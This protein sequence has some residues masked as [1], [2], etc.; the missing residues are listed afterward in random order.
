M[1]NTPWR[2]ATAIALFSLAACGGGGGTAT[3]PMSAPMLVT[4]TTMLTDND[5]STD[6]DGDDG[7]NFLRAAGAPV[8]IGST[9]DPINGDQNPYGL[10]VAKTSSPPISAGDLVICNFNDGPTNT[11]G[12]GTTIVALHPQVGSTPVRVAQS[13]SL[14]GCNALALAPSDTI[15]AADFVANNDAI[16]R[17][18]GTIVS[19][20]P[21]GPWHGPFGEAFSATPGP[22]GSAAFYVTN[23]GDGS[24]V[25]VDIHPN[26][27]FTFNVIATG[28]AINGGAPGSILGPSGLQYDAERDRLIVIDGADNSVTTL[29]HVSTI[30]GGGITVSGSTFGGPFAKRARRIFAGAPLNG[31]ISSALLASGHLVIGNTLDAVGANLMVEIAMNGRVVGTKN[32]DTGAGGA[33]FGMV[34]T[35]TRDDMKLYFND[36]ND[37]TLKVLTARK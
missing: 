33:L 25:R 23:A 27:P 24:I 2:A 28:F 36:D 19:T 16:V 12:N 34:A 14:Q 7:S 29:R 26:A 1:T 20:L 5:R 3:P 32:V 18:S 10:D 15:W 22:F 8:T 31:P 4:R 9:V 30:P 17:P 11:Q 35:G 37:N 6:V 13:P 21:G